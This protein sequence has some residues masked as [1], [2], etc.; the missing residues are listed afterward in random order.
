MRKNRAT[1]G[2]RL[3]ARRL[4]FALTLRK[5]T[6]PAPRS[7][8]NI[9]IASSSCP[10]ADCTISRQRQLCPAS[11]GCTHR[12]ELQNPVASSS[13][14][15]WHWVNWVQLKGKRHVLRF[16]SHTE[17]ARNLPLRTRRS[18][19]RI[20]QGAPFYSLQF[21]PSS[22]FLRELEAQHSLT[23]SLMRKRL[24]RS[25]RSDCHRHALLGHALLSARW[26]LVTVEGK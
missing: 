9:A 4:A 18:G 19:V 16:V 8:R 14:V 15:G 17:S 21:K 11:F 3:R 25:C 12:S 22:L 20:S 6:R 7:Q 10:P 13:R 26:H 2:Q 5:S 1:P 24:Q 23:E